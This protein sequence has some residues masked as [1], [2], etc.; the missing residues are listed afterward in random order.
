MGRYLA[1]LAALAG[2]LLLAW[3]ATR[4][5]A[6]RGADA[7]AAAFSAGRAFE[8]VEAIAR[9][10]H[11]TGS[12]ENARVRDYLVARMRSLGLEVRLAPSVGRPS[13]YYSERVGPQLPVVNIVGVLPGRDRAA[14]ALAVMAHYDSVPQGPGAGDDAAGVAAALEIARALK[15]GPQP[16]RD[17]VFLITDG[18]EM[19]LVGAMSFFP[20]DRRPRLS[21]PDPLS[22]R[23]GVVLNMEARGAGGRVHMFET[24][25]GNARMVAVLG[26]H[27]RNPTA[28]SLAV[29][30][31]ENLMR[32]ATDFTVTRALGLPGLNYAFVGRGV[33]YHEPTDTPE[34]LDRGSLQ[35][36]GD[37]VLP[38][39]R[40]LAS[41]RTLPAAAPNAVYSDVLGLKLL[42][43]PAWAGWLVLAAAALLAVS[44][45]RR[46]PRWRDVLVGVG[47][48]V[49]LLLLC[50]G[51][52]R[53]LMMGATSLAEPQAFYS[54]FAIYEALMALA[55]LIV[56]LLV[57][58]LA[59][60][61]RSVPSV[62][63]GFLLVGLLLTAVL[64]ASAPTTAHT[65]AWPTL[66][67]CA[68]A[69]VAAAWPAGRWSRIALVLIGAVALGQVGSWA[70]AVAVAVGGWAPEPLALFALLAVLP[71]V[72]LLAQ[73]P[74]SA[75]DRS[76]ESHG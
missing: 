51:A 41:A 66:L 73:G 44:A 69:A 71:L 57:L 36:M 21:P 58:A 29:F 63:L 8:D 1:L 37:Q 19:G 2:G 74:R 24:G 47:A 12:A 5:P 9:R 25:P 13:S 56:S 53:L 64:Q 22:R 43:Y 59:A 11:P 15:A 46:P 62:W 35:H 52:L 48:A 61:R 50:A 27:A 49:A 7:P 28:N 30:I 75:V 32:N 76:E 18:E 38:V 10:P 68:A 72:P 6:P 23:I 14:P 3:L 40:A 20:S 55:C 26:A 45:C 67:A 31:Y 4:T 16:A 33:H 34:N 70:H 42:M 17:V 65:A 54:G 60:R 39:A